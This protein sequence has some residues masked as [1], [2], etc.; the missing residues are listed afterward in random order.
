MNKDIM[1]KIAEWQ[2]Q[3]LIG[4]SIFIGLYIFSWQVYKWLKT[5]VWIEMPISIP[6]NYIGVN[7]S[8]IYSPE[9]WKGIAKVARW[10][11]AWPSSV[12]LPIIT[13]VITVIIKSTIQTKGSSSEIE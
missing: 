13:W 4:L 1:N 2:Q 6:I 11:C 7:L 12:G 8:P 10:I 3:F 9:D 5:S